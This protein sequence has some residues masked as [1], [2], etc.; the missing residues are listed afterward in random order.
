MIRQLLRK[1]GYLKQS[2]L[3]LRRLTSNSSDIDP[4]LPKDAS[5]APQA[6]PSMFESGNET[7]S[8][9]LTEQEMYSFREKNFIDK[10]RVHFF[11][12]N[13]GFGCAAHLKDHRGLKSK[14]SGGSGGNGGSVIV[15]ADLIE[16]D[17]SFI[18]SKV[19]RP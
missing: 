11:G 3:S 17:L 15:R 14:A 7:R 16:R 4:S 19:G 5:A 13:G 12:G 2:R 1:S 6:H 9:Y 8:E 18:R 10:V